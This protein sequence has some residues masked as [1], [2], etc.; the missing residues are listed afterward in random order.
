MKGRDDLAV[1]LWARVG[2]N[3]W[4]TG[5]ELSERVLSL[6]RI[7]L[8]AYCDRSGTGRVRVRLREL[9]EQLQIGTRID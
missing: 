4:E 7:C 2:S 3:C 8:L 5:M 1:K 6:N 9:Y